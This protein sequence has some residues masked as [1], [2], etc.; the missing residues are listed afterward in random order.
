M[1]V[2]WLVAVGSGAC[3]FAGSVAVGGTVGACAVGE[4][5]FTVA[6]TDGIS[7]VGGCNGMVI[8]APG[9]V[10][11]ACVAGPRAGVGGDVPGLSCPAVLD[12]DTT[13]GGDCCVAA[14]AVAG[15]VVGCVTGDGWI[16]PDVPAAA[17]PCAAK[18]ISRKNPPTPP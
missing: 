7:A 6:V 2:G 12:V 3:V 16:V 5:A 15:G 1:A 18:R 10:G 9:A 8:P 14:G 17:T 11:D 4:A 13:V